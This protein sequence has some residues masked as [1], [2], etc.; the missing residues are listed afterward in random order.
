MKVSEYIEF[1]INGDIQQLA[2]ANVG[3]LTVTAT[4]STEINNRDKLRN[5][6]NLAN[7]ELHKRFGIS[8]K[9]ME[10]DFALSGEEFKLPDDF[11]HVVSCTFKDG[12]DVAINNEQIKLVNG[13]DENVSVMFT[14]P[15]FVTIKGTDKN[16]RKD[17][18]LTYAAAP[19][20]AKSIN[21]R[22]N[23]PHLYTEAL[24]NYAAYKAH[25]TISGDMKA[26]NNTFYLRYVESCKQV[27]L[28]GLTNTIDILENTRLEDNGF[29]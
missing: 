15:K 20:L 12:E 13:I 9:I 26:E 16:G 10:L 3:D 27:K 7:I 17:M 18:V 24:L 22:L 1:L 25:S 8:K 5:F 2:I 4:D 23:L 28:L 21:V 19:A 14:D 6:I 11:M 29:I